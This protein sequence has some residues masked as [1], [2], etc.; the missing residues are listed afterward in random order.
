MSCRAVAAWTA[1]CLM[2]GCCPSPEPPPFQATWYLED[3]VTPLEKPRIYVLLVNQSHD[4]QTV[5]RVIVDRDR[6]EKGQGWT[7]APKLV[8]EPGQAL[9]RPIEDFRRSDGKPV[10]FFTSCYLPTRI[11]VITAAKPD[12][13]SAE[14]NGHLPSSLPDIW[15]KGCPPLAPPAR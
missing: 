9:V 8:L 15:H 7:L 1:V 11:V 12:G 6:G 5:D 3:P 13:I 14:A 2:T 4:A 10:D